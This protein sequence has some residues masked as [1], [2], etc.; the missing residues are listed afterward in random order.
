MRSAHGKNLEGGRGGGR[1]GR[2][3]AR[4]LFL[5]W[6]SSLFAFFRSL[7]DRGWGKAKRES[8]GVGGRGKTAG[9]SR[10]L[11]REGLWGGTRSVDK[12]ARRK[13][14]KFG[15]VVY[16]DTQKCCLSQE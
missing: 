13:D 9:G 4:L 12:M 14:G 16:G 7:L 10:S 15:G 3:C 5:G 8:E 1:G 6:C 2:G 11:A